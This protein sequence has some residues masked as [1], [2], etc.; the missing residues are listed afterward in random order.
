MMIW[1][2]RK[3]S[4]NDLVDGV[5]VLYETQI[6]VCEDITLPSTSVVEPSM[7][8]SVPSLH[9]TR[10]DAHAI[11]SLSLP[12]RPIPLRYSPS[13][14]ASTAARRPKAGVTAFNTAAVV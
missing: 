14:L 11:S 4:G 2:K 1:C 9:L 12:T 10:K 5:D 13:S 6:R 7:I 3:R 8:V